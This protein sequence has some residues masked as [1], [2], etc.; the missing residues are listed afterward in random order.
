MGGCGE[1]TGGSRF[2]LPLSLSS[3]RLFPLHPFPL[4]HSPC[5][6]K[7]HV[8]FS[9]HSSHA[10]F[11]GEEWDLFTLFPQV[12]IL[13]LAL[14]RFFLMCAELM[15]SPDSSGL[16]WLLRPLCYLPKRYTLLSQ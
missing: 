15:N 4:T 13:C 7:P 6:P 12:L 16:S 9:L 1:A 5:S 8:V 3:L 2:V 14:S 10:L 11:G